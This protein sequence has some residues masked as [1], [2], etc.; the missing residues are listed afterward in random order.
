MVDYRARLFDEVARAL[1][2]SAAQNA[3]L[4]QFTLVEEPQAAFYDF[5]ARHRHDLAEALQEVRLVLVVDVGGGTT[6]FTLIQVG[7]SPE[8]PLLR[9]IAVGDHLMLGGDNMDAALARLVEER[10]GK[11]L[12]ATQWTQL[13]QATRTAKE[14]LLSATPAERHGLALVAEGSRLLGGTLSTE[15]KREEVERLI[16]DGFFPD[17]APGESPRRAPRVALQE[18]GL[19]Y[20]QDPAVTRHLTAFLRQHATAGFEALGL[21][22][23]QG[24][25]RP[26]AILLNGGVFNSP[27]ITERLIRIASAWWPDEAP[28]RLLQHDSLELAVA[29][30]AAYYGLVRRGLGRRIGGGAAHAFYVGLAAQKEATTPRAVCLIP[31]GHEEGQPPWT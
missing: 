27:K 4:K 9:R 18:L 5:T 13:A 20:A 31:R 25:P 24:L 23:S 1:T 2:V 14:S 10:F 16:L 26:D 22:G 7:V 29:R 30:G 6:D 8:G 21:L 12:S 3:G 11:K 19:P 15:L 17:C 28:I